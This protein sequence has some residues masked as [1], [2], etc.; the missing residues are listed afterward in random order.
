MKK[1]TLSLLIL[2]IV[3]IGITPLS[4]Q[5]DTCP[6]NV[7]L[8]FSRSNAACFETERNRLC[9]GNGTNVAS[10]YSAS[11]S[12][13]AA[14][15]DAVDIGSLQSLQVGGGDEWSVSV[16]QVQSNLLESQPG[17]M[18]MFLA[19]GDVQ[20]EN[21]VPPLPKFTLTS[22]GNLNIR[23]IP[24]ADADIVE[25]LPLRSTVVTNGR[26]EEGDWLRILMPNTDEVRWVSPEVV[27]ANGDLS[28]LTVVDENMQ[29]LRPFQVM[30]LGTG[31]DDRLCDGVTESGLLIQTPNEQLTDVEFDIN[32]VRLLIRATVFIQVDSEYMTIN[33]IEGQAK[34]DHDGYFSHIPPGARIQ[35]LGANYSVYRVEPYSVEDMIGLPVN[36][37]NYRVSV[38]PPMGEDEIAAFM[39]S[40]AVTPTPVPTPTLTVRQRCVRT[41]RYDTTA[42]GG[43]G[44]YYEMVREIRGGTRLAPVLQV[45]DSDGHSWWQLSDSSWIKASAA[46]STE[47]CTEVP[48]TE[49][50]PPPSNNTLILE[51]CATTNGPLRSGQAVAVEFTVDVFQSQADAWNATRIDPGLITLNEIARLRVSARDPVRIADDRY[52]RTFWGTWTAEPG[53]FRIMGKR[54]SYII[55]CDVTVLAT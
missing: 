22:T 14:P 1:L 17:R 24:D 26:T 53:T 39:A 11:D 4:A 12:V 46:E 21:R 35:I 52:Y 33:V 34:L 30:Y 43:P 10:F 41:A 50:F 54:L 18:T 36:N 49:F 3:I 16:I 28:M 25:T 6:A 7:L 40:A 44:D 19:F 20:I 15:G 8:A 38:P 9:Y 32:G 29:V 37:L 45:I 55:T 13:F 2:T 23:M 27:T 48:V 31:S 42:W 51:T 5:T 47:T